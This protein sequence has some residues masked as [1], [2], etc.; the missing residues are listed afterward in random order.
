MKKENLKQKAYNII[1]SKI[2]NCEYLPNAFLNESIL[3]EEINS[4]RTPIREALNKL[5]QENLV[6]IMPKKGV[7]VSELSINEINM[8]Y[9]VR[10]SIEPYIIRTSGADI[11][12]QSLKRVYATMI[13]HMDK[14]GAAKF[15][16]VDDDFHRFIVSSSNNK[17][18]LQ[19]MDYIYNQMQRMRILSGNK[20]DQRLKQTQEEH[21]TII[22]LLIEHKIEEAAMSMCN[23]LDNSKKAALSS[24]L[25]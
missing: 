7:I 24:I 15:Y 14:E 16:Q 23:H 5:E 2:V 12:K 20:V 9:Q 3:M 8:I 10:H 19:M 11:D 21:L 6:T 25:M 18:F 13:D 22:K 4:S 1:K 17:Y